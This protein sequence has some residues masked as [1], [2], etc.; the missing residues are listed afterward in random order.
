MTIFSASLLLFLVLDPIGN[1]PFFLL[2]L[3]KVPPRRHRRIVVRELLIALGVLLLFMFGGR[4]I[5]EALHL[6]EPSLTV[7]GGV[8]LFLI[9]LRMV[10]PQHGSAFDI[11]VAG[12]PFIVPLAIPFVAGP[13]AVASVMLISSSQPERRWE[14]LLALV[15]AW[16][17]TG[18]ILYFST[19]LRRVLG[20]RVITAL[21][22]LMG[23]LLSVIAVQMLMTGIARFLR[24]I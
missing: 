11:Q 14:W 20:D 23:M 19:G 3:Q 8:L 10:F 5:L 17:A 13:S 22:R 21:E 2:A 24:T 7:A 18:I 6:S 12:E 15:L 4:V 9:A 1:I 16:L